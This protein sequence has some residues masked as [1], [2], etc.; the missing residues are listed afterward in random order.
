MI[1]NIKSLLNRIEAEYQVKILYACETGSR[2][3][4]F[5]SPDSDYDVRFIYHHPKNWY[6]ALHE[7]K[8]TIEFMDGDLDVTGW[9]LRKSLQLLKKS[10]VPLIERFNSPIIYLD[11]NFSSQFNEL[12]QSFYSPTSVFFHHY[13]LATKFWEDIKDAETYKLKSFFY[14]LRS[15]LSCIWVT[16]D[17]SVVPMEI[18]KLF[19]HIDTDAADAIRR[20][21]SLKFTVGEKYLHQKDALHDWV[22]AKLEILKLA[23]GIELGVAHSGIHPLN[24]FFIQMLES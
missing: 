8:D 21:I 17:K 6:L 2:A 5:P 20:L 24:D 4:G 22:N 11:N 13:S 1:D 3:W 7:Q 12:I 19:V 10:N 23:K 9:D 14:L 18:E 16:K 15:L